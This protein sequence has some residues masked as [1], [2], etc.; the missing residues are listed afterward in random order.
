MSDLD[1]PLAAGQPLPASQCE[2]HH[3]QEARDDA[4]L[5]RAARQDRAAF[6]ALYWRHVPRVYRFLQARLG[7]AQLAQDATAQIFLAALEGLDGSRG[8]GP[9]ITW[10]L[11]S[12]RHKAA[13]LCHAWP[14][15]RRCLFAHHLSVA[16]HS[17]ATGHSR[18]RG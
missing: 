9:F 4:E 11:T 17:Q 10:L 14:S 8:Q 12:A 3:G 16:G 2:N 7:D 1:G 18:E 13:G 15:I 6:A 5:V